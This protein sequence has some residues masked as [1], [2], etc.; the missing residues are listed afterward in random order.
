MNHVSQ[1]ASEAAQPGECCN[2]V[3][4]KRTEIQRY[5]DTEK[6]TGQKCLAF[7][8]VICGVASMLSASIVSPVHVCRFYLEEWLRHCMCKITVSKGDICKHAK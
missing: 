8:R 1:E 5:A 6:M 2:T 3:S 4:A 7:S